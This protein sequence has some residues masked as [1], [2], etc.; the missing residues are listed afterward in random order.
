MRRSNHNKAFSLLEVLLS[1]AIIGSC[2]VG[3]LEARNKS[4]RRAIYAR[5]L[6]T[7]TMLL[8]NL[9]AEM[10]LKKEISP[11]SDSGH[12]EG[13]PGFSWRKEVS[14]MCIGE[15]D[16]SVLF[17]VIIEVF[18]PGRKGQN[19]LSIST[20]LLPRQSAEEVGKGQEERLR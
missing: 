9:A 19:V 16:D 10:E 8:R 20:L 5:D 6:T 11:G 13:Y 2:L 12:F 3:I 17:K 7:A 1:V 4:L 14:E 15:D 18:Y